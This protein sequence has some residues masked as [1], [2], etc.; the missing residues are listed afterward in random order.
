MS[1][2]G[3]TPRPI[4]DRETYESN[5]DLIF[6]AKPKEQPKEVEHGSEQSRQ[7]NGLPP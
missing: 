6:K 7:A 1:G 5:W 2:K 4:P 3:S